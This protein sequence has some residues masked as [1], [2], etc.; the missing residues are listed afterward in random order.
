MNKRF[1]AW[2]RVSSVRQLKEG[3]S[4]DDQESRLTE[5]ATKLGGSIL[6]LYKISETASK[7]DE[8]VT[9]REFKT[10][11]KRNAR[12]LNGMLFVKVDRAARNIR[13]WADL[14]Q[15]AEETDVPLFFPDQPSAETPAGRMQRRMSAV[16]ASYQTDQQATDIRA[17]QKRRVESGLPL[18]KQYGFKNIRINGRSLIEHDPI[19]APKVRRIF[20][21][22]AYSPLTLDT[23][24]KSLARQGI[25]YTEKT[26]RF[27]KSTLHRVLHNRIY[28]GEV[29]YGDNWHRGTFE[30]IVELETFEAVRA[31]LGSDFKVYHKP[32]I[33]FAGGLIRCGHCGNVITGELKRKKSPDGK[34][35]EYS[36]YRC[37]HY[38]NEGHPRIRL[39]EAIID[40]ELL[41]L[42]GRM[43]IEDADIRQW[44]VDV[45]RARVHAGQKENAE[46]RIELQRQ[47]DAVD[48]KLKSLLDLRMDDEI[49]PEEYSGNRRELQDR[50][51][52]VRL[53]LQST[54]IDERDLADRAIAAFE[55]S[56]SLKVRWLNANY[57]AKRTILSIVLESALL[58]SNE[59]GFSLVFT[60]RKPFDV[61]ADEKLIPIT[62]ATGNRTLFHPSSL[63]R[64]AVFNL[65][66]CR[67]VCRYWASNAIR[68]GRTQETTPARR[69]VCNARV[70]I[71]EDRA[72]SRLNTV[73]LLREVRRGMTEA[74]TVAADGIDDSRTLGSG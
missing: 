28:L 72:C 14:E 22:F 33:T 23:L 17:G 30:P 51:A 50:Q 21:L 4:L 39:S 61:L 55:L 29:R 73:S 36:Y 59:K 13:D 62:G 53:Q 67:I 10:F 47:L 60:V 70:H 41:K 63:L 20:E 19:T 45:L 44:F 9:F 52:G 15:L 64:N 24:I 3:F 34:I 31:K 8:R 56:Q 7:R 57:D 66:V 11:V 48:A 32:Q 74:T 69:A 58:N 49:T 25:V 35:R 26:P 37:T 46:H 43:R 12:R 27:T 18:G 68:I 65:F 38:S 16:F 1:V 40:Q 54:D 6:Q 2:A 42:F 5:F 71:F